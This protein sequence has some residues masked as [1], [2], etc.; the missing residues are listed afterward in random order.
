M[1]VQI[2][3]LSFFSCVLKRQIDILKCDEWGYREAQNSLGYV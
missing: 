1:S 2:N 3:P